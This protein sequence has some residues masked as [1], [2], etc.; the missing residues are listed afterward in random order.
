VLVVSGLAAW[1]M[2]R[3]AASWIGA[4]GA[5]AGSILGMIPAIHVLAD[6]VT[7]PASIPWNLP[8]ASLSIALDPLSAFFLLPVFGLSALAAMYGFGYWKHHGGRGRAGTPWLWSNLLTAAMGTVLVARNGV[9]FL[10]AWEIMTL[11]SYFLVTSE[12]DKKQ[13]REAGRIYLVAAHVGTAFLLVLFLQLAGSAGPLD[14][15]RFLHGGSGGV[16]GTLFFLMMIGFGVKAGFVPL[17][18]WLPE[19][20]PAAPSH[21]SALM[22]GAMLKM[23]IYGILRFL[24]YLGPPPGAWGWTLLAVGL[25]SGLVGVLYSLAQRDLKRLLAYSSIENIGILTSSLGIGLLGITYSSTPIVVL[26]FG[27]ALLHVLNHATFKGLLFLGAGALVQSA[28]SGDMEYL[29]GLLKRLPWTGIAFLIGAVAIAGLPPMNGFVSEFLIYL[30]AFRAVMTVPPA[31]ALAGACAI[32]GLGLV[33]GLA[34]A[35]FARAFGIAFLGEPRT[36]AARRAREVAPS[37]RL[38]MLA[39][40]AACF[41]LTFGSVW[42]FGSLRPVLAVAT[43][44]S[45]ATLAPEIAGAS[46]SLAR[47]TE[48]AAGFLV[49]VFVVAGIRKL[50][51]RRRVVSTSVTWDCGYAVPSLRGGY[52]ASS[53]A[54]PALELFAPML[55][56]RVTNLDPLGPFPSEASLATTTPDSFR[57]RVFGPLGRE[58]ARQLA[59]FRHIQEGR[60]Q[61]YILYIALTLVALLLYE[62]ARVR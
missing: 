37:L 54:Q 18:V 51:L 52:T 2:S 44:I 57:E 62:F 14:F 50:F 16:A 58:L 34:A 56:T 4:T 45:S 13:A 40:A 42:V 36:H 27:A 43:G 39:L 24:P 23:G 28:H 32:G 26:G 9:L 47:L 19:A 55:G 61:I 12:H 3:R 21:V 15:D 5:L 35:S 60:V 29:G 20:H 53:F 1:G 17:H 7:V 41:A 8:L 22:S 10:M 25:T 38:P 33:G 49:L 59:R 11:V 30:A 6:G 46:L 31:L 48:V